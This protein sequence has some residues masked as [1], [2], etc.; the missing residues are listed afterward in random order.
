MRKNVI[1]HVASGGGNRR[2]QSSRGVGR[3]YPHMLDDIGAIGA[4]LFT[5]NQDAL[6]QS[7]T[8]F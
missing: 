4:L 3:A 2:A 7:Q 1:R 5:G 6:D 8:R